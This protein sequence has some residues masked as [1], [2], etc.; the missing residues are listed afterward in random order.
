[1]L[2]KVGVLT[3]DEAQTIE[4]GL[5]DLLVD[6]EAGKVDLLQE[7]EDIHMLMESLLTDKIGDVGK[8]LHTGR[9]RNDQVALDMRLYMR[10]N[11]KEIHLFI[12]ARH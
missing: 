6:I 10:N 5:K 1:M 8:K 7:S 9:S 4:Q 12:T 3:S 2:D 11:I